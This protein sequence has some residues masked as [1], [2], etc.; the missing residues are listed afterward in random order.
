MDILNHETPNENGAIIKSYQEKWGDENGGKC[1]AH[2]LAIKALFDTYPK[3]NDYNEVLA[4]CLFIN[5]VFSTRI[6]Y[7]DIQEIARSISNY[8][9]FDKK[10]K[11]D[12]QTELV[13]LIRSFTNKTYRAFSS[14]YCA[15]H[16]L[17]K[18][19]IYD[20]LSVNTLL[21]YQLKDNFF[22]QGF[23]ENDLKSYSRYI[24]V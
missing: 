20:S 24:Q 18:Y 17:S 10:I 3:N 11:D 19:P 9:N 5:S 21:E 8:Q 4:K 12:N 2:E 1:R 14:K 15:M 13:E 16:N 7:N 23:D 22:K 6:S